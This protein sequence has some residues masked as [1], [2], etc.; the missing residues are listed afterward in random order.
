MDK[1]GSNYDL[2]RI[3]DSLEKIATV[4]ESNVHINIDHAELC[5]SPNAEVYPPKLNIML[6]TLTKP[7]QYPKVNKNKPPNIHHSRSTTI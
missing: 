3:A 6:H 2:K 4:L 5:K 7:F 1:F